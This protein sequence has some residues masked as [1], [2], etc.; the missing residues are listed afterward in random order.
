[1]TTFA[2]SC[3]SRPFSV[4]VTIVHCALHLGWRA[5]SAGDSRESVQVVPLEE[6]SEI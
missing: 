4:T 3:F 2:S 1:L 5:C 6:N